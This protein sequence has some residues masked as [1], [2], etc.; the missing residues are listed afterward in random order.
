MLTDHRLCASVSCLPKAYT[1]WHT[2][3]PTEIGP[4]TLRELCVV[5]RPLAARFLRLE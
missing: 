3:I 4:P 1:V 2:L 5:V